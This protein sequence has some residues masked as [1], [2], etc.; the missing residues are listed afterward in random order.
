MIYRDY[1]DPYRGRRAREL[2]ALCRAR[3]LVFLVSSDPSLAKSTAA[4]G[5]HLPGAQLRT[6]KQRPSSPVVTGSCHNVAE[7]ERAAALGLDAVFLS[8]AFATES[9]PGADALGPAAFK[10][11]AAYARTPT[12][13]LGGVDERNAWRLRCPQ[14]VGFGAIGAFA[15]RPV[16]SHP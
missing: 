3:S 16:K 6:A 15:A 11:L 2:A 13:A 7:L 9:H 5:V 1:D 10:R 12:L 8:P 4:D 14:I